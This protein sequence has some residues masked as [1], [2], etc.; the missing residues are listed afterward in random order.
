MIFDELEAAVWFG[1]TVHQFLDS[2]GSETREQADGD[3]RD[4]CRDEIRFEFVHDAL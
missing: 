1:L 4:D 3:D 2:S